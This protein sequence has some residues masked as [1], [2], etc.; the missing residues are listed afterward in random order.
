MPVHVKNKSVSHAT[1]PLPSTIYF[2]ENSAKNR[3]SEGLPK[4]RN[5]KGKREKRQGRGLIVD[6]KS[7]LSLKR[8]KGNQKRGTENWK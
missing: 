1:L 8:E 3:D 6:E 2:A 7:F 5:E 4:V